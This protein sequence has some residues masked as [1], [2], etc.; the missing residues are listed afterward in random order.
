[1]IRFFFYVLIFWLPYS[2]G[3]IESCVVIALLVLIIKRSYFFCAV[4]KKE[5][6][7]VRFEKSF[8]LPWT[9]IN[10]P[11]AIFL[12][13][14]AISVLLSEQFD[15]SWH[16]FLTK[17]VEWFVV[18]YLVAEVF[19]TKRHVYTVLVILMITSAAV[20]LDAIY[21][22]HLTGKDIFFGYPLTKDGRA[23]GPFDAPTGLGSYCAIVLV[24]G[25]TVVPI[26]YR[27]LKI[28]IPLFPTFGFLTWGI[29]LSF[30]RGAWL[31]LILGCVFS[32]GLWGYIKTQKKITL[33]ITGCI[34]FGFLAVTGGLTLGVGKGMLQRQTAQWRIN[35]WKTSF[36]MIKDKPIFGHGI[37]TYMKT[38]QTY[39]EG[40]DTYNSPTYAHNCYI[41]LLVEV[42][43]VGFLAFLWILIRLFR[44]V[45]YCLNERFSNDTRRVVLCVGF[46]GA[47]FTILVQSFFD[48]HFYSLKFSVL[49]W[50]IIG[51]IS[52]LSSRR[53]VLT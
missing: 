27:N 48:T 11:V 15:Q 32:L 50:F 4:H 28:R 7:G 26:F 30:S 23:L 3:V 31:G 29:V 46:L 19:R 8:A 6:W 45:F 36:K 33:I 17:T 41:Q 37:N 52:V 21:Q 20:G 43:V 12:L 10:W 34:L 2:P 22:Y 18:F 44:S 49:M 9:I 47:L 5:S 25:L 53:F 51:F 14:C 38:F 39:R 16:N 40:M 1:M 24:L 42:G 35:I 13:T